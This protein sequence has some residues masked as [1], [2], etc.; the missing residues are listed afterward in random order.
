MLLD[1]G[2]F[3]QLAEVESLFRNESEH[4]GYLRFSVNTDP[5][6]FFRSPAYYGYLTFAAVK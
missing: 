4:N 5:A 6:Y 2:T 1:R 3:D